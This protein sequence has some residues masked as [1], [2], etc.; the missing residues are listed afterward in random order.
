MDDGKT[1][2][3]RIIS[4]IGG[5]YT[6]DTIG[7]ERISN[8]AAKGT[9]R[10]EKLKPLPGDTAELR[11]DG[12]GYFI[13]GIRERRNSL[14][15]PALANLDILF[16][17]QSCRT[18]D[19]VPGFIDKITVICEKNGIKPVIVITK[20]ELDR[21][22]ADGISRVY[23]K[24][25]YDS[26]AVSAETCE[27]VD[28]LRRYIRSEKNV[29]CAFCGASGVG[30][31]T[32]LN[33]LYPDMRFDC[34]V[35]DISRKTERGKNTTRAITLYATENG[36]YIADTPGFSLLDFEKFDLCG[37]DELPF[38]F[39]EFSAYLRKC[40]Y[41]KCSHTKEDGCA[42]RNAVSDGDIPESRYESYLS[43]YENVKNK[44]EWD[45]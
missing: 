27:G 7:G 3:A 4:C 44:K 40:R 20:S 42:I 12:N 6:V 14:I 23:E 37:K 21:E 34:E 13:T 16:V 43:L 8:I 33:A 41:T 11:H 19:P 39:P 31:S 10:H 29:I 17:L 15:R 9:F 18:P 28:T 2:T 32:L 36:S 35:G 38:M 30:K 25:G 5:R 24:C 22:T 1:V 26:F 45:K